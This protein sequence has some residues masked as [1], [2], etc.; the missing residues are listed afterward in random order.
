ME[1]P[2]NS[3]NI[4]LMSQ[5]QKLLFICSQNRLRSLTAEHM[6]RGF[7]GYAVKSAG[8]SPKARVRVNE[9]HIG[10]ADI[11]FVMEKKHARLLSEKFGDALVGKT[12]ICLRIPDV[13]DYMEPALIEE[14]KAGL[15]QYVKVPGES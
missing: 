11:I 1:E 9:G 12:V 15:S 2:R 13:Y 8:T 5:A 4:R 7:T 3:W 6:Y 10:W 14:L